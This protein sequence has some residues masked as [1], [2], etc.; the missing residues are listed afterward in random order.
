M[1]TR[2]WYM[3]F[4][5]VCTIRSGALQLNQREKF[6]LLR[7]LQ[8]PVQH[9][10]EKK[11]TV[12]GVYQSYCAIGTMG[13]CTGSQGP[14]LSSALDSR[15]VTQKGAGTG[16]GSHPMQRNGETAYKGKLE[17]Y[18]H[19]SPNK[20]SLK[21]ALTGRQTTRQTAGT[22]KSWFT[23]CFDAETRTWQ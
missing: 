8:P 10:H 14:H 19:L 23:Q 13:N 6:L 15:K 3:G 18:G 1:K 7:H 16:K 9:D 5:Q 2:S 22:G 20:V 12:S 4:K 11:I 21:G 17:E